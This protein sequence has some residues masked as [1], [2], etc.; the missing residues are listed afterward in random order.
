VEVSDLDWDLEVVSVV[1]KGRRHRTLPLSPKV[2]QAMDRYKRVRDRYRAAG[3][4]W[5]RLGGRSRLT[6]SGIRQMLWRPQQAS[7]RWRRD[8]RCW[9]A[10]LL[11]CFQEDKVQ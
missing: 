6:D 2:L 10:I 7:F 4:P 11:R 9:S 1:A 5:W 3:S 8:P